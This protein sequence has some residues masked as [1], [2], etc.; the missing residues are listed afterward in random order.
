MFSMTVVAT[1]PERPDE[2]IRV[3]LENFEGRARVNIRV[4]WQDDFGQWVPDKQGVSLTPGQ[5]RD[6]WRKCAAIAVALKEVGL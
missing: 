5:F 1:V 2:E 4:W 6:V 3:S